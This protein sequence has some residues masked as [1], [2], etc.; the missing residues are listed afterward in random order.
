[1]NK[2]IT[3]FL[4]SLLLIILIVNPVQAASGTVQKGVTLV[5]KSTDN[6][7]IWI[8]HTA[9]QDQKAYIRPGDLTLA[10]V[11]LI[12]TDKDASNNY[13]YND[14]LMV[15]AMKVGDVEPYPTHISQKFQ[16]KGW[17][18]SIAVHY[19]GG[20]LELKITYTKTEPSPAP[21]A[22]TTVSPAAT[23]PASTQPTAKPDA[24][25]PKFSGINGQVEV[26][27][28]G[29][30]EWD[31]A[32]LSSELPPGTRIK[33]GI[34]STCVLS[35]GDMST[36][37]LK[38]ESEVIVAEKPDA[39]SVKTFKGNVWANLKKT[40]T[41]GTMDIE[42]NQGICGIKGTTIVIE[43]TADGT[44]AVKVIE[45]AV[46]V[47]EKTY[48]AVA[49]LSGGQTI[50]ANRYGFG[51]IAQ[52]DV[53]AEAAAWDAVRAKA[54]SAT[55]ARK[56]GTSAGAFASFPILPVAIGGGAIVLILVIVAFTRSGRKK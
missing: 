54:E 8:G 5:N 4:C 38:P 20:S 1:M 16:I 7:H 25:R 52:F 49:M 30:R 10:Y 47:T 36:F 3:G 13:Y 15:N 32:D 18:D 37:V 14:Y 50:T 2:F 35:F 22:Q 34:D 19:T 42:M 27:L 43:E 51:A 6:T 56:A 26:L 24:Y 29:A 48:K 17:L 31:F 53:A 39:K 44:S 46:Q 28:P 23:A 21:A 40:V 12:Y 55:P 41:D 9:P 45:G 33:T 11:G